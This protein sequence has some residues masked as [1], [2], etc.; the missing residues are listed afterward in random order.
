MRSIRADEALTAATDGAVL[1]DVRTSVQF[2]RN[3][4]P[5][6]VNVPLAEIRAQRVPEVLQPAV[7]VVLLCDHGQM[8]EL[9]G[10]YLEQAGFTDVANVLGG[11]LAIRRLDA[12]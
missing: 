11:L 9:A 10:L 4:L 5:G 6:S 8:S 1:V 7:C 2:E 12:G 3:G